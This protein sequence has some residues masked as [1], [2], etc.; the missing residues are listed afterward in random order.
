MNFRNLAAICAAV[1]F[2][3]CGGSGGGGDAVSPSTP[4]TISGIV[5]DD[6][7]YGASVTAT[8]L[9]T[10]LA[11]GTA[12]TAADGSYSIS[13]TSS[14]VGTAYALKTT[15]GSIN[16]T[17][18]AGTLSAIYPSTADTRQSNVT[19]IT[20][21]L[22]DA[23]NS[24]IKFSGTLQQKHA[25][26]KAE[27]ISRGII[28]A[29]YFLV[30]PSGSLMTRLRS[31]AAS[32]GV[33]QATSLLSSLLLNSPVVSGC[34]TSDTTCTKDLGALDSL[35]INLFG[36]ATI[37]APARTLSNCRVVTSY[38]STNQSLTVRTENIPSSTAG[39]TNPFTCQITGN[40]TMTLP[41]T[42]AEVPSACLD[43]TQRAADIQYCVTIG[44][45]IAPSYFVNDGYY[46]HR[47]NSPTYTGTLT[48][49]F[50]FTLSRSYGAV[51]HS[52]NAPS[53]GAAE[54]QWAGKTAVIFVHGF[55]FGGSFGGNDGTW[56][57]LPSLATEDSSVVALN[58]KW[59]TDASYLTVASELAKAVTYAYQS[60][61][62]RVH[63]VAH[64]FGGVLTR[65]MLQNLSGEPFTA[66]AASLVATLTTI[67]APHSGISSQANF[68]VTGEGVTLPKG[69]G[70]F[71][72]DGFCHQITCYQSGLDASVAQWAKAA[73]AIAEERGNLPTRGYI[74]ARLADTTRYPFPA[75]L[76]IRVLIGQ[77]VDRTQ[78]LTV[79]GTDDGLIS[80]YG[81]RF[82]PSGG[83]L[84]I[85]T[86]L[87]GAEVTEKILGLPV[88]ADAI[89]GT[90][91]G[92][93]ALS[94]YSSTL[95]RAG[96]KHST[97]LATLATGLLA[98][99][100]PNS[101]VNIPAACGNAANCLH[102]TWINIREFWFANPA[103]CVAPKIL[104]GEFC[105]TPTLPSAGLVGYWSFNDCT[106]ADN[107]G[108]GRNGLLVGSPVCVQ[109]F[110]GRGFRLNSTNWIEIP[111]S[112]SL[113]F[114]T[115][116]TISVWFNADSLSAARLVDKIGAGE[117]DGYLLSVVPSGISLSAIRSATS[118]PVN[119]SSGMFHHAVVSFD[120]GT[121]RFYL[122]GQNI[123][124]STISFSAVL[125]SSRPLRIGASQGPLA[126]NAVNFSGV[127][128]EVRVY[129]RT[130]AEGE[131]VSLF[132]LARSN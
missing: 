60:T 125:T 55:T 129:N 67:G 81:Q 52:S 76:K 43:P 48:S 21:S 37:S 20:S 36:G 17:A 127:M 22:Y 18:F 83:R 2:A 61:G 66:N 70:S 24:T 11:I 100:A 123:G 69:W 132:T 121:V 116:F 41:A 42:Q 72:L 5:S 107:S 109:T 119:I 96:Y 12:L 47:T 32:A 74:N 46:R 99:L 114:T 14:Q 34:G 90:S 97:L 91:V 93:N 33:P 92:A 68:L 3:A 23:A 103:T 62:K 77:I 26:V 118:N 57:A 10:G 131:I 80:Y 27:A 53:S 105:V 75:G 78:A 50:N 51:L 128:D 56:G 89:P 63:I 111:D 40:A 4:T 8:S 31:A 58:F 59:I 120:R 95:P 130:L 54:N 7:V 87:A 113:R 44:S 106:A 98:T 64:S 122:D 25:A 82:L 110:A 35:S 65:A 73:L 104:Q 124:Q 85:G 101:E 39:S 29:D 16:G 49:G 126:V 115:N 117:I 30:E 71:V 9:D 38:D 102:D 13:T 108:N 84:L 94:Q 1:L 45:G 28:S 79:F 88:G 15:G 112:D 86:S 19:L 6:P